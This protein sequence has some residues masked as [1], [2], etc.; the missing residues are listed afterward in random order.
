MQ[1]QAVAYKQTLSLSVDQLEMMQRD[2]I[3]T[4]KCKYGRKTTRNEIDMFYNINT[5]MCFLGGKLVRTSVHNKVTT[6]QRR[7]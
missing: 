2:V 7:N 1:L 6:T 5:I 3:L 4:G